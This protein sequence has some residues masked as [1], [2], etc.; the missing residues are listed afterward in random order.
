MLSGHDF[1]IEISR[2]GGKKSGKDGYGKK[3]HI[4]NNC[5]DK[6]S[7]IYRKCNNGKRCENRDKRYHQMDA[8]GASVA[9]EH[10]FFGGSF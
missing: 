5:S 1:Q 3:Q 9:S 7:G 4:M 6:G 10:V 2:A 8:D